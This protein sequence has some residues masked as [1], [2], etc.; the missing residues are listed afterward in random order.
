MQ[1]LTTLHFTTLRFTTWLC[2]AFCCTALSVGSA[3][4]CAQ[5]NATFTILFLGDSLTEG[6]GLDD[7]AA[8]PDLIAKRFQAEGR[9]R[10]K[11]INGGISATTSASALGLLRW[12]V[13]AKPDLLLLSF[14]GNDGLRGL[15]VNEMEKN[16]SATIEFAQ[17]SGIEVAL[18][19]ML[20]PPNMGAEYTSAF[21]AVF[22]AL[23]VRYQLPLL[24]FLLDGV[25]GN[26]ALNQGD[27]IHPNSAGERL[28][29]DLVWDFLQPLLPNGF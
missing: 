28:V 5:E 21:A 11:V 12:F 2:C 22:P 6:L 1:R 9:S 10:I 25:A 16:L 29:A 18:S 7:G 13:R 15:D 27:G 4:L 23:A 26:P 19:G 14:G 3:A 8:F 17:Q 24:P 20:A